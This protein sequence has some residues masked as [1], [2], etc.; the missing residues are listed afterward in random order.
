MKRIPNKKTV[1]Y[2]IKN[3]ITGKYET[4]TIKGVGSKNPIIQ[5]EIKNDK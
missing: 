5:V 3:D 1:I 4:T 2:T